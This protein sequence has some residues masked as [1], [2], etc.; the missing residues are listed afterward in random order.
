MLGCQAVRVDLSFYEAAPTGLTPCPE[1]FTSRSSSGPSLMNT[2]KS[3]VVRGGSGYTV[4]ANFCF[5]VGT[6]R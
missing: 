6:N 2:S 3:A 5:M 4:V 1:Y